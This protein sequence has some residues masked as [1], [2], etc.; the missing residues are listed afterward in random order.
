MLQHSDCNHY[1]CLGQS[2]RSTKNERQKHCVLFP[3]EF[4]DTRI[5]VLVWA[6]FRLFLVKAQHSPLG[7]DLKSQ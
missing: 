2:A 7:L 4:E 6:S 3:P 1:V 5:T